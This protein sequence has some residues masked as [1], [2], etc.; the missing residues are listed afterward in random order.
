MEPAFIVDEPER[1][2]IDRDKNVLTEAVEFLGIDP[3]IPSVICK[4]AVVGQ[5]RD[6]REKSDAL[7]TVGD[8]LDVPDV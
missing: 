2:R 4:I 6:F 5:V 3:G 8:L 1:D 7:C